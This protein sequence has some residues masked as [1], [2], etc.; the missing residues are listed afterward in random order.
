[1][2]C[3]SLKSSPKLHSR[4]ISRVNST[5]DAG[6]ANHLVTHSN[7]LHLDRNMFQYNNFKE[8]PRIKFTYNPPDNHLPCEQVSLAQE[9]TS[10][11]RKATSLQKDFRCCENPREGT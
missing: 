3:G 5:E 9:T 10:Q 7:M 11:R 8:H 6:Q 4:G 1:M 2:G